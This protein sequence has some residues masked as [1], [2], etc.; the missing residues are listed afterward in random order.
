M[1]KHGFRALEKEWWH[2]TWRQDIGYE[3]M[4]IGFDDIMS[5]EKRR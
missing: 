3:I 4:D 1:S 5:I 2:Y